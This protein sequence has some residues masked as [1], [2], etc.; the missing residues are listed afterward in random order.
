MG[1]N[2][3][4]SEAMAISQK[5]AMRSLYS[6]GP[7]LK[8]RPSSVILSLSRYFFFFFFYDSIIPEG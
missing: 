7:G 4:K 2:K 3:R 1:E 5:F 6:E 8:S